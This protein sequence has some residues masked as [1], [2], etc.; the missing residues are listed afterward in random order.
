MVY[1]KMNMWIISQTSTICHLFRM[2]TAELQRL[3]QK[4]ISSAAKPISVPPHLQYSICE[5]SE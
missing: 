1:R 2:E 4:L 3:H 5:N